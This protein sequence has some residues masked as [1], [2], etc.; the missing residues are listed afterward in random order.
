[1]RFAAAGN[2]Y[3]VRE[4]EVEALG[5]EAALVRASIF[6]D[7]QALSVVTRVHWVVSGHDGLIWRAR[8][9]ATR[10]EAGRILE[11]YGP[12]LGL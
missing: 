12:D 10:E 7:D 4:F 5:A 6:H 3:T 1:M 2:V 9:V 8:I 11:S